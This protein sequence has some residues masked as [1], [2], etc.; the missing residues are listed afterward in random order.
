VTDRAPVLERTVIRLPDGRRLTF[1]P[2]PGTTAP[3]VPA[4]AAP[5][6]PPPAPGQEG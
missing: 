1:Y 4:P 2:L 6:P 5:P 3:A